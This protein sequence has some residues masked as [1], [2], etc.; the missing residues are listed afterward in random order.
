MNP[1]LIT[2]GVSFAV[3]FGFGVVW[4]FSLP[5]IYNAIGQTIMYQLI[6][7]VPFAVIAVMILYNVHRALQPSKKLGAST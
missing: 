5:H 6:T 7:Y 1:V 4:M 2:F 3:L